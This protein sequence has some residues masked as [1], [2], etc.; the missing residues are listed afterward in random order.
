MD[1]KTLIRLSPFLIILISTMV[2][3]I[4]G[5]LIGK[6]A[7]IPI[8]LIQWGMFLFFILQYGGEEKIKKWVQKPKGSWG[9]TVFALFIGLLP[10]PL[11]LGHYDTLSH[12]TV[13]FPWITLAVVNPWLEEFYWRGLLMD[14]TNTW[15]PWLSVLYTSM[16]FSLSHVVFGINSVVNSGPEVVVSTFIMGIIWGTVY[17]Q[18]K[19]LR[20]CIVAHFFVDFFNLS[21]AAF[22]DLFETTAW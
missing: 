3:F 13:W 18:T 12:W 6:W 5:H 2:A 19:S 10:L 7:F 15:K 9:W 21:A 20:W 16:V 14:Y 4:S 8:I 22:L 1:Q 11:F 17:Y